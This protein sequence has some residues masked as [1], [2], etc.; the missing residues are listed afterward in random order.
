MLWTVNMLI[1][2]LF[3]WKHMQASI[4]VQAE[5]LLMFHGLHWKVFFLIAKET[6]TPE[7]TTLSDHM[8]P[9]LRSGTGGRELFWSVCQSLQCPFEQIFS[10]EIVCFAMK[11]NCFW[12]LMELKWHSSLLF[13]YVN[14]WFKVGRCFLSKGRDRWH[15]QFPT[16]W[17]LQLSK[18][19]SSKC[20]YFLF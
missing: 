18:R 14:T 16:P 20:I 9:S 8:I 10:L 2:M 11:G 12:S 6:G 19:H 4:S 17:R 1:L 3:W 5:M 13:A 15:H 7:V